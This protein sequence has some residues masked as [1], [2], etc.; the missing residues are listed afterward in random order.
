V[1]SRIVISRVQRQKRKYVTVIVGLDTVP[2]LKLKDAVKVFGKKFSS[3]SS[4]SESASGVKEV[5]IQGDV[6]FELPQLLIS[7]FKV[8][9]NDCVT[10]VRL[11][12]FCQSLQVTQLA[13]FIKMT[14]RARN[15]A[16]MHN[17]RTTDVFSL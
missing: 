7:E 15:F 4:L 2:D 9:H 16:H 8:L 10:L 17:D 3:G 6:G 12:N 11:L 5:V 1:E 13:Y 14:R